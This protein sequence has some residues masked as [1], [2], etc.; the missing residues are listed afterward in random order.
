[1]IISTAGE[2][3]NGKGKRHPETKEADR[4]VERRCRLRFCPGVLLCI[5]R[6]N[7]D[8]VLCPHVGKVIRKTDYARFR[9]RVVEHSRVAFG[10]CY[11]GNIDYLAVL[12]F[13]HL[14]ASGHTTVKCAS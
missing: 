1:M 5:D 10:T 13:D 6:F 3:E 9:C 14:F 11:R 2:A 8:I 4:G 7:A 12:L